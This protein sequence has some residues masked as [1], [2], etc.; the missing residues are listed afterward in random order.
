[1]RYDPGETHDGLPAWVPRNSDGTVDYQ[2]W[3]GNRKQSKSV[4]I[5]EQKQAE[6]TKKIR[7][8]LTKFWE[9]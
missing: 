9:D 2:A 1:M 4:K 3:N 6:R 5:E 7:D 8:R